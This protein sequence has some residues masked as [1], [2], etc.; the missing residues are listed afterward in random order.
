MST[1]D[2]GFVGDLFPGGVLTFQ[3]GISPEIKQSL[4]R[5]DLRIANLES[6]LCD[7][8]TE[9]QVKMTDPKLGNLVFSPEKGIDIL[10]ELN[11][12][13][14]SLANNHI[15]D[16]GYEGIART[17]DILD[18]NGIAHF[19]AGRTEEEARCPA[20]VNV[21]GKKICFLGYFPPD[22]EAPYPPKGDIGGLNQ[23]I[24][25]NIVDD[26][27][28]YKKTCDYVF[29][30]PHWG[31]EHTLYPLLSNVI[32]LAKILKERPTGILGSHS[33]LPQTSFV[34]DNIV[35]A[36]SLGNFLFPDRYIVSPRKTYYPQKEELAITPHPPV[37]YD[38]PHV[39]TLTLVKMHGGGRVG[40]I[41]EVTLKGCRTFISRQYTIL[42]NENY[43][44]HHNISLL[45]KTKMSLIK[46]LIL[47]P[48]LYRLYIRIANKILARLMHSKFRIG[49]W[50]VL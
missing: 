2:L 5:F 31:K 13:V 9:C 24:L 26:I 44:Q 37:T 21:K 23:F 12:N 34:K 38:F 28:R 32:D 30:L 48:M 29:V 3:G 36:M 47:N 25:D 8:G 46:P 4:S 41:C 1:I 11:I 27:R 6:P 19:G 39:D 15:C 22:W 18:K 10:K 49:T 40:L 7:L 17:I 33:H 50:N 42:D 43:L 35:V 14:V 45:Y 20:I 16:C